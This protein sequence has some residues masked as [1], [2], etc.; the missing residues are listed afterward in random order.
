MMTEE[1]TKRNQQI[2]SMN[3]IKQKTPKS[4]TT[5][6]IKNRTNAIQYSSKIKKN[7]GK[8][9]NQFQNYQKEHWQ[10]HKTFNEKLLSF[11]YINNYINQKRQQQR[12]P[13]PKNN[14][15]KQQHQLQQQH[16]YEEESLQFTHWW[17]MMM[18]QNMH[19]YQHAQKVESI[20]N[21][22][23][24]QQS[25]ATTKATFPALLTPPIYGHITTTTTSVNS[26]TITSNN[27]FSL[28]T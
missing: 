4:Q 17:F 1:N 10:Q 3:L 11:K 13:T 22:N 15:Q 12:K 20:A 18:Q 9:L 21:A 7:A 16:H 27:I 28:I 6:T 5:P 24:R 26:T 8:K 19:K 23:R 14:D 25:T 2:I